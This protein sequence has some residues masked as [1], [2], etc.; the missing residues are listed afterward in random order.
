MSNVALFHWEHKDKQPYHNLFYFVNYLL[1][2]TDSKLVTDFVQGMLIIVKTLRNFTEFPGGLRSHRGLKA[3][4]SCICRLVSALLLLSYLMLD[5]LT[6]HHTLNF[7]T[8]AL[9][10]LKSCKVISYFHVT[11]NFL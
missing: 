9:N 4:N 7:G 3:T 1:P 10:S 8:K 6:R 11:L 5:S 2:I